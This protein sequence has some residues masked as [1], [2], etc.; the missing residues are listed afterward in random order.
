MKVL[1]INGSPSGERGK[2]G[3]VLERFIEGMKEA[4][5]ETVIV[6][7]AGKKIH[8]C[9]GELS[10]W[11]KTPGQCIHK[12][13]MGEILPLLSD[14]DYFVL[15][16]PVYVDGMTGLMKNFIDRLV[17]IAEPFFELRNGHTRHT[18]RKGYNGLTHAALVSVCGF[19]E[20]DNFDPLVF[21]IKAICKNMNA[22]F[23]GAVLRPA[24]PGLDAAKY[25]H[26]MKTHSV[27]NAI[28]KAGAEFIK[29]GR[30]SDETA[31]NVSAELFSAKDYIEGGNREFE[32]KLKK[33]IPN[34]Q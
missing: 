8:H 2:T 15:A 6:N 3:W 34:N 27:A 29:E 4:G 31:K 24:A 10:C 25:Y 20:M 12:D 11:F 17:P 26:P 22:K 33:I 32:K 9:T 19:P 16:T 7:L 30:I 13:D 23:A 1:V 21:H 28:K 18:G 14:A 5:A